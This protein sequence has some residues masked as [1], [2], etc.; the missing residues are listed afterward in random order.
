M[1]AFTCELPAYDL[2]ERVPEIDVPTLL[3]VGRGDP[4]LTHMEWLAEMPNAT[5]CVF[6]AVG[7]FWFIEAAEPFRRTV[8]AFINATIS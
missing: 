3:I 2:R 6:D 5:L 4:Y 8:A 7:H 1:A